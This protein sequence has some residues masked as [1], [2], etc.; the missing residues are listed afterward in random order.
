MK[1]L[2]GLILSIGFLGLAGCAADR[3]GR[4][5]SHFLSVGT[6]PPGG[7]FFVFGGAL[8]EVLNERGADY[9][10]RLT[11]EATMGSQENIRRLDRGELDFAL[12][13]AAITYFAVRGEGEWDKPYPVQAVMTLAPN[14]AFFVAT[15]GSGIRRIADL[16]GRRV[17]VGPAGAGM[18]YFISPILEAHGV[19]YADFTP[20]YAT[21]AGAVDMLSDGSAAAAFLGGAVPTASVTQAAASQEVFFVPFEEEV[22]RKLVQT[23]P[24]F[25]LATIPAGTYPRQDREFQ[26]LNVGSMHLITSRGQDE[27]LVYRVTRALF[28]SRAMVVEKHAA[29]RSINPENAV[30]NTGTAFHPGAVR[31]YRES[32]I[33]PVGEGTRSADEVDAETL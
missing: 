15:P 23:Y 3:E 9:G 14:I 4:V 17:V 29:G 28:E 16:K 1:R 11:A 25:H 20:L 5:A 31:Y 19:S 22:R 24:F 10:W 2:T 18:E 12:S 30:R 21:Q 27:E 32:G 13:N 7:A 6:A 8:A 33:W 26:C